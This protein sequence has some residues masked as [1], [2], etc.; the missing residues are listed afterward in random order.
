MNK[1]ETI[2]V[3]ETVDGVPLRPLTITDD[4]LI[5]FATFQKPDFCCCF[6]VVLWHQWI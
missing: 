5:K 4:I 1:K 6:V 2:V 3:L